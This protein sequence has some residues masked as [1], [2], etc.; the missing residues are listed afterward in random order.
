M[1]TNL[2]PTAVLVRRRSEIAAAIGRL[3][4]ELAHIDG[5]LVD[6]G[7][8]NATV[9]VRHGTESGHTY[10]RQKWHT[11]PCTA[12]IEA[13]EAAEER[14]QKR[15]NRTQQKRRRRERELS[16]VAIAPDVERKRRLLVLYREGAA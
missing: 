12:C 4:D 5:A 8:P 3:S 14:R 13:Y 6:R 15:R 11:P 9:G 7:A 16:A 2:I 10:H 1:T